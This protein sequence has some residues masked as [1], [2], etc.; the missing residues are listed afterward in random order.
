MTTD[1]KDDGGPAFPVQ[2]LNADGSPATL[3]LGATLR[4]YFAA[5]ALIGLISEHAHPQSAGSWG[6]IDELADKAFEFADA[7]LSARKQEPTP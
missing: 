7:M 6:H 3:T 4:D 5:K 2:E 1:T